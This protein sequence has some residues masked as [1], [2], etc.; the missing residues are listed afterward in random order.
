M[1][2]L[3]HVQAAATGHGDV[4]KD[5]VPWLGECHFKGLLTIL[6]L[7]ELH[8]IE[9]FGQQ[10]FEPAANHG[11]IVCQKDFHGCCL[12]LKHIDPVLGSNSRMKPVSPGFFS[13]KRMRKASFMDGFLEMAV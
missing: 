9:S 13:M 11:V 4:E 2:F 8:V 12:D 1:D 7:A 3:E 5:Q 10:E 6:G